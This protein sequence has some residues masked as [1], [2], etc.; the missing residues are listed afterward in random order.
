MQLSNIEPA[1]VEKYTKT[2]SKAKAAK[3]EAALNKVFNC[4]LAY[5]ILYV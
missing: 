3:T 5:V 1:Y 4:T 2:L